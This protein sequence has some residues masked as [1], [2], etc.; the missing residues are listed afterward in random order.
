MTNKFCH[1]LIFFTLLGLISCNNK[2]AFDETKNLSQEQVTEKLLEANKAAI[3]VENKQIINLIDSSGWKMLDTPTGLR[4]EIIENGNGPK[5]E[6]GKIAR[7]EYETKLL[8]G[9]LIYSSKQSGPKEFKIGS[10]GV[11]SGVEE[12]ILLLRTGDKA[13]FIIPSYLAHGLSGDQ[14]RIPP[15]ATLI[16]TIKL[17]ELK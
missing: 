4:Y 11:E 14:D 9:E 17:I 5:A 16:Y 10:G 13:R 1:I 2:K 15:K 6:T 12:G 3:E 7:I 8:N